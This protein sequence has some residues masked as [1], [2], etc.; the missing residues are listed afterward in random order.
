[1][2]GRRAPVGVDRLDV[3]GVG[4]ALPADQEPLGER[5]ALVDLAL[6]D[7]RL[8]EP[9]RGLRGVRQHHHRDPATGRARACSSEMS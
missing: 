3:L 1:M 2:L 8:A 5:V 7:D 9:A 4:L 6:R